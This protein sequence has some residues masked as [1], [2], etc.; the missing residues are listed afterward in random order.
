MDEHD[1]PETAFC[2][3]QGHYEYRFM[4]FGLCNA[5]STF[6][7]TMDEFLKPFLRKFA[8]V[9]FDDILV[10]S[11]SFEAHLSHFECFYQ[12]LR[13][14][15]FF[16]KDSKC[17]FGK[18]QLE[19]LGHIVSQKGVEPE[20]KKYIPCWIGPFPPPLSPFEDFLDSQV[21]TANLLRDMQLLLHLLLLCYTRIVFSGI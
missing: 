20:P 16:L 19:Y 9:F 6:Q 7:A 12:A 17:L 10:Y 18:R 1:I 4:P 8:A 5:P 2:T 13:D 14:G 3:H 21:F 15:Q 11:S